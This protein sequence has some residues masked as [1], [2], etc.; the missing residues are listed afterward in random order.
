LPEDAVIVLGQ[1]N[2]DDWGDAVVP[3]RRPGH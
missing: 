3:V 1:G 2:F